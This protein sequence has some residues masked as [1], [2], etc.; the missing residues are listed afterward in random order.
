MQ[1]P[2]VVDSE[3]FLAELTAAGV[4]FI[5]VGGAASHHVMTDGDLTLRVLDLP[6][7][8]DVKSKTGRAKDRAVLPVLLATLDESSKM[9]P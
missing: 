5:V 3:A 9:Q 4:E 8:I 1:H 2:K 7:L 6:K